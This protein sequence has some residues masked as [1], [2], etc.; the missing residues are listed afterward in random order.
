MLRAWAT[1]VAAI[2]SALG[3]PVAQAYTDL[4]VMAMQADTTGEVAH[5]LAR[6]L[7]DLMATVPE[8]ER[9]RYVSLVRTVL[10]DTPAAAPLVAERLPSLIGQLDDASLVDFLTQGVALFS[11]RGQAA[12][13]F[14][15]ME[16]RRSQQ[17]AAA[18]RRGT[19]LLEVHRTLSLYAR[20]HCGTSVRV[21]PGDARA[22]SDGH[23]IYLPERI[24]TFGDERDALIYRVLTA[25]GAAY[26]EFGTL[27]LDVDDLE[28]EWPVPTEA[29]TALERFFRGF[30]NP[31]LARDLFTVLENVRV[32]SR[33]RQAYP[34]LERQMNMLGDAWRPP[35]PERPDG[36]PAEQV[37]A[38]LSA[39]AIGM[40]VKPPADPRA[41]AV[42]GA[43]QALLEDVQRPGASVKSSADAVIMA[44]PSVRVL[45]LSVDDVEGGYDGTDSA[46]S[47]L[48]LGRGWGRSQEGQDLESELHEGLDA[49][50]ADLRDPALDGL[51]YAEMS[52]FLDRGERPAGPVQDNDNAPAG[53]P[54]GRAQDEGAIRQGV[55][56]YPEWDHRL[57]DHKPDWVQV[58]EYNLEPGNDDFVERVR[59]VHG[60]LIRRVRSCFEALRPVAPER[61]RGRTDGHSLDLDRV[62]EARIAQRAG[63]PGPDGLYQRH[64]P[65]RRDVA[66]AFLIDM[67]SST[68][69]VVNQD[70]KRVM[71][72]EQEALVLAAEAVDALGDACAIWG[73]SGYGR[74][75][76][77]FYVAKDFSDP[78][79][80]R[81]RSRVG[82]IGWKMENRDGAA[83][84]H[85]TAKLLRQPSRVHLLMLLS[86]G[87]PL[88]CGC[89]HY[90]DT[91][92]QEDTR[93]ALREAHRAGVHSFCITVDAH[94]RDYLRHMH[95]QG[96]Y[97]IIDR[98]EQLPERLPGIYRRLTR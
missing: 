58:T 7:P 76:V 29:E 33:L 59:D 34:G 50:D 94:G 13:S 18:L 14:L 36:S 98:V 53:R 23:H 95:G 21:R 10:K 63:V 20:A 90:V 86:D 35:V 2:E 49:A 66:V 25:R 12:A 45:L 30:D 89:D 71:E 70:G 78:W 97:T 54:P 82:R 24:D 44:Y 41:A 80:R 32:E 51:S 42:G 19:A 67:S 74:D 5:E 3:A 79:D 39:V 6:C 43:I 52:A 57:G 60:P 85:A 26:V 92:A 27:G 56:R 93:M 15:A 65:N 83:I 91:Y 9:G 72:V 8:A 64:L 48:D 75:D 31:V 37:I 88:D 62:I 46:S 61:Q 68:N 17:A 11:G 22:F 96:R 47:G 87:K 28:G 77:A 55:K 40:D 4:C 16:T 69:E 38:W 81:V 1:Q 84:R 73:Y